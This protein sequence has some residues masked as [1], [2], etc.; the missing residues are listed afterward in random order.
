[1]IGGD[2][3]LMHGVMKHWFDLEAKRPGSAINHEF[4]KEH[5]NNYEDLKANVQA[6]SWDEIVASSGISKERIIELSNIVAKSKNGV[7]VWALGLTMHKHATDNISQV[8]NLALLRGW[9][10]RKYNGLM[11]LRG[12]SSVQ[13]SG[14]M[15]AD[16]FVLPGGDYDEANRERI[17]AVWNFK[18]AEWHGDSVGI[19]I[20]NAMLPDDKDR[21]S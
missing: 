8:W 4:V 21:K 1:N 19:T 3:A 12:H 15:G 14:E 16:P 6:Q 11:P 5:V 7:M 20:E 13:G 17:E 9:L 2:I 10:G 18:L